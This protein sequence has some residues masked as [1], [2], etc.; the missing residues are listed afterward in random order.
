MQHSLIDYLPIISAVG[1]FVARVSEVGTKRD[2]IAG[3]VRENVTFLL[4]FFIGIFML[5]GS[6]LEYICRGWNI[7]WP[8]FALGWV[9]AICS[10][11]I[12]RRTIA[13]LGKF[14][15]L[16]VEI[17][18][19]HQLVRSGPFRWMRHPVYF[20]MI[21]ELLAWGLLLNALVMLLIFPFLFVPALLMRVRLEEA[22]L[23]EKFGEAYRQF[24]AETPAI[25]PY[26]LPR[27][28]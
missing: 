11:A 23:V 5:A 8:M 4:F 7:S 10:F 2:T 22:A 6:I 16:H 26:K 13:A 9:S 17:R 18:E 14:W 19:E 27:A 15:S 20:S 1:I 12:R 24:Q 21:L 28:K 3:P 25:F